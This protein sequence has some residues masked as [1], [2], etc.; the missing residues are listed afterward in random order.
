MELVQKNCVNNNNDELLWISEKIQRNPK[1]WDQIDIQKDLE[2]CRVEFTRKATNT[3]ETSIWIRDKR[4]NKR[5]EVQLEPMR[6][7]YPKMYPFGNW[8]DPETSLEDRKKRTFDPTNLEEAKYFLRLIPEDY[9]N[10]NDSPDPRGQ[11]CMKW[12]QDLEKWFVEQC[13]DQG[14]W[15]K[16][17]N[18]LAQKVEEEMKEEDEKGFTKEIFDRKKKLRFVRGTKSKIDFQKEKESGKV[19]KDKPVKLNLMEKIYDKYK[20]DDYE[21][22][23]EKNGVA[24]EHEEEQKL[25]NGGSI[26]KKIIPL[27]DYKGKIIPQTQAQLRHNDVLSV[28]ISFKKKDVPSYGLAFKLKW[29]QLVRTATSNYSS[30]RNDLHEGPVDFGDFGMPYD[31]K[32][33]FHN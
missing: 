2:A 16:E 9:I 5:L 25:I 1:Y 27:Y 29:I 20:P 32:S 15:L 21:N 3:Q 26:H 10:N 23:L 24:F 33:P 13:F 7:K 17:Q 8:I 6:V 31:R 12:L 18:E 14:M 4:T 28:C 22:Q 19:L 30:N 11:A